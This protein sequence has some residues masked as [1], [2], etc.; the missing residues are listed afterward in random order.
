MNDKSRYIA[1]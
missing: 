1:D